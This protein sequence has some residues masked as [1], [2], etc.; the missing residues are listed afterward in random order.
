MPDLHQ[1]DKKMRILIVDDFASMRQI[2]R[3]TLVSLGFE[4]IS[5]AAGAVDAVRK[6]QDGERFEFIISDWNMPNMTGLEF[7]NYIR[8]SDAMGKIPFLMITAEAQRE[9]I[10]QA[11]KAGV[12]QYIVKPFT[13]EALQQKV[14][15]IFAKNRGA[16]SDRPR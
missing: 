1:V 11:A 15:Q 4:N 13:A 5:E 10:I 7:L 3:K 14:E 12:S 2:V 6:I 16:I 9:N 8:G